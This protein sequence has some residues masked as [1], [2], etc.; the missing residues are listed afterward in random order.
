M[1]VFVHKLGCP[2]NDVDADYIA[3]R[4]IAEG[5]EPVSRPEDAESIIVNT[6]G[7]IL[8]AREESVD[9]ILRLGQLKKNGLLKTLYAAGCLSQRHGDDLLREMPELDGAFGIGALDSLASAVTKNQHLESAVRRDTRKLGFLGWKDRYI[10]DSFPWAY[11]KISDGC[12]RAC[13]YCSIPLMRGKF[14]SRP[15]ESIRREAEFLASN[16]KREL[17]LVSQEATMYGYG[18]PERPL[19]IDLLKDL[20]TVDGVRWIRLLYLHP[21]ELDQSLIDYLAADNKTV[22]YYDLPLQ[23]ISDRI[24]SAMNRQTTSK[25]IRQKLDSIR[26]SSDSAIIRTTFMVGFP[27]ETDAEF[28]E[29]MDFVSQQ[30]FERMGTFAFSCEEGTLATTLPGAVQEELAHERLDRLMTTQRDIAFEANNSLIGSQ[31]TVIIDAVAE[32]GQAE[33]RTPGDTPEIDPVVFVSGDNLGVGDM[34]TVQ[35]ES[36]DGYDLRGKVKRKLP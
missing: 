16:G 25:Q 35:I 31:A 19:L 33:A 30:R 34:C 21:A 12:D 24:L 17:I 3:A 13:S 1:K 14:R 11:L 5:H 26:S 28:E 8:P 36:A 22:N 10:S 7:F 9:E 2:K 18:L 29:L 20:E 4:L 6:C 15:I 27:G 23:H 32:D